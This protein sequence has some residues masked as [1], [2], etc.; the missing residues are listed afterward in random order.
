MSSA[1]PEHVTIVYAGQSWSWATWIEHRLAYAGAVPEAVRWDPLHTTPEPERLSGLLSRP[2]KLLLLLDDW[3][4]RFDEARRQA[5]ADV[6]ADLMPRQG[7]RV[8]AVSITAA[9]LPPA[10]ERLGRVLP[11]RGLDADRAAEVLLDALEVT[12]PT[13]G[14]VS[15]DRSRGPR[16]PEDRPGI[17]NAPRHNRDFTGRER[18]LER[19][20]QAFT[21]GGE[22]TRIALRGPGGVGKTQTATEYV[23][24]YKGEY[25]IV[26]WVRASVRNRAR[27]DFARL[28][29]KLGAEP[30]TGD[31]LRGRIE[32][33]KR[34]LADRIRWL[35]VLDGA[36]DPEDLGTLLPEGPGHL[37]VTTP[38]KEWHRWVGRIVDLPPFDREESVDFACRRSRRL[39]R[40]SADRLAAAVEDHPLLMDQTAAWVELNETADIDAYIARIQEGDPHSVPVVPSE[41]YRKEFQAAWGQTV[42][43]L[44]EKHPNAYELLSLFAFFSPDVIPLGLVQSARAGDLPPHLVS[45]VTEPSSWNTALRVLSEA[46]SMRLEYEQGPMDIQTVGTLRMHRLFHRFVRGHLGHGEARQS[47]ETAR[48]VLVAADPRRPGD[49]VHWARYAEVIPH[50]EPTGALHST[51][52]DVRALV[53]NCIEYLRIRGEYKEGRKLS[54]AAVA[55]W[56]AVSPDTDPDV[57]VAVHQRAN[58]ERRLGHYREAE[59]IGRDVLHR[60]TADPGRSPIQVLR[61]KNGLGGTLMALGQYQEA[62]LLYEDAEAQAA[63]D[64]GEHE[65]P[66]T[67]AIRGNLAIALRL[68]G[69]YEESLVLHRAVLESYIALNGGRDPAT[70]DAGLHTAWTLR[71][72]GRYGEALAIQELNF[73]LHREVLGGN[74]G[75]TLLAQHNLA[76]CLRRDGSHLRARGLMREARDRMLR[77]HGPDHP[78]TL[79]LNTDYAMLLRDIGELEE[80]R[81][82]AEAAH[83]RYARLLGDSHPY[84]AGAL[85][86]CALVQGDQGDLHGA[87]ERAERARAGMERALGAA[88]VWSVGCAMNTATALARTGERERA[89]AL[90]RDALGRARAAVGD[91]HVLTLNLAAG[92]A[93]DLA[94]TGRDEEARSVR[95]E[96]V[97]KLTENFF[98]EHRQVRYMLDGRRPYWDFEPQMM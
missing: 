67:L 40:D 57:L 81:E 68:L 60:I 77:R 58:M 15:L 48:R 98:E 63:A 19:M 17:D 87:R 14:P 16:F 41:E 33:A 2:G 85:D 39:T 12:P 3:F 13:G 44:R 86:N 36:E 96:A 89:V 31:A 21:E 78:E 76:L 83:G 49:R 92:L 66:R 70:L 27:E 71:L 42:N 82:L 32:A 73:R 79:M 51:D 90:G 62:R 9:S 53:L 88:H 75:Q 30:D 7:H 38:R 28:A 20:H 55:A 74:H 64:L 47:A 80:A 46:T 95:R 24:R 5:W 43:T 35:V 4:V 54:R 1:S 94:E 84:V 97:R 26:W 69:R 45:L 8:V 34:A 22:G 50:L 25:D 65:V 52:R 6:L 18:V 11:L 93:Q 29:D 72:L 56:T 37:L 59:R 91:A 23:H 10:A 61:A